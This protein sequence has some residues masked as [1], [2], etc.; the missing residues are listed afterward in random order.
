MFQVKI[1]GI[2]NIEDALAAEAAGA[3][4]MG[5]NFFAGSPRYVTRELAREIVCVVKR[6]IHFVGVF[7]NAGVQEMFNTWDHV[8]F[9]SFQLHGDESPDDLSEL[10]SWFSDVNEPCTTIQ[11]TKHGWPLPVLQGI[12]VNAIRAFRYRDSSWKAAADYLQSCQKANAFPC[13]V[14]LDAYQPGQY[15]GTGQVVDWDVVRNERDKLFGLP[16]I[17]A[18]GLTPEN[19][20]A[21]ITTARPDAVDTASG[22][23]VSP[24]RKDHGLMTDFVA[25]ARAAFERIAVP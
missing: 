3:D 21:A 22:V 1:C 7:V 10:H 2:T 11:G 12:H 20:A 16:V 23:E 9:H 18:G 19:V 17:L 4:A 14:L 6:P 5:L 24:G 8:G 13:A 15:G 25:R